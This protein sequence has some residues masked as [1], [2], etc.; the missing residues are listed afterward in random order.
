MLVTLALVAPTLPGGC[1]GD[2]SADL[3]TYPASR[4]SDTGSLTPAFITT[5]YFPTDQN[6]ADIFLSDIPAA[7]LADPAAGL[8]AKTGNIVYIHVFLIPSAGMT[9]IENSACN[10]T[11]RHLILAGSVQA[12]AGE[13][14]ATSSTVSTVAAIGL[15]GGAGFMT[16]GS[17]PGDD[18]F[19]GTIHDSSLRLSRATP[20]FVDRLGPASM[21]GKFTA[22][23][24]DRLA[25]MIAARFEQI[26]RSLTGR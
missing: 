9:P 19:T 20:G 10:V 21:S 24:D 15:Y 13:P 25:R 12:K 4:A 17:D 11:V 26:S 5:A 16:T 18:T 3:S 2:G 1:T 7:Q 8:T 6:T 14:G 22:V 23:R